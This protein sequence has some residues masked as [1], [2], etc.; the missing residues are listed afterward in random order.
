MVAGQARGGLVETRW[1]ETVLPGDPLGVLLRQP[2]V[3]HSFLP[4]L[5]LVL[6]S[7]GVQGLNE[8]SSVADEHGVAGGAH[9]HTQHCQPDVSHALRRLPTVP[10][11]QHVAHGLEER[12]GVQLAPRVILQGH[13]WAGEQVSVPGSSLTPRAPPACPPPGIRVVSFP[14]PETT[15]RN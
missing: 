5:L 1:L 7:G 13:R 14:H 2:R 3:T 4:Y 10:N 11:A 9:D 15:K 8:G 12:K 6:A